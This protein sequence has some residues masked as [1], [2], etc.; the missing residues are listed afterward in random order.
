MF[1]ATFTFIQNWK[2]QQILTLR[3][4]WRFCLINDMNDYQ[5]CYRLIFNHQPVKMLTV[6]ITLSSTFMSTCKSIFILVIC[7]FKLMVL[8]IQMN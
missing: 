5:N 6:M 4:F 2:K 3:M 8:N 1:I 7:D